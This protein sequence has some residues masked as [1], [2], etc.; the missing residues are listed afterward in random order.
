MN[1]RAA[2][3]ALLTLNPHSLCDEL[4]RERFSDQGGDLW[5][6]PE[7]GQKNKGVWG[8]PS[9]VAHQQDSNAYM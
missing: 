2:S 7:G 9:T 6:E 1:H 8:T 4:G 3:D 5:S